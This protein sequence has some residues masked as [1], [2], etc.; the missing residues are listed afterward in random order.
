TV[1]GIGTILAVLT[2]CVFLVWMVVPLFQPASVKDAAQFSP[3]WKGKRAVR[4]EIDEYGMMGWVLFADGT[5][6]VFRMD[7]GE[8]LEKHGLFPNSTVSAVSTP[9]GPSLAFGFM[10]GT[11]RLGRVSFVSSFLKD[12]ETPPH[13]RDLPAGKIVEFK[14]GLVSRTPEGQLRALRFKAEF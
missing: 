9:V 12:K 3:E 6:Q 10:D 1:G 4:A 11:V 5:L 14:G 2:I 13:L 7:N 8:P